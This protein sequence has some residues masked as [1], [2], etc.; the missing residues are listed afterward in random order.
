MFR[1]QIVTGPVEVDYPVP[2]LAAGTYQF[3]CSIHPNMIG[4]LTVS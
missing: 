4:T 1:G 2:A 3:I